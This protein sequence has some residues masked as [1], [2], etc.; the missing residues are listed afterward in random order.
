MMLSLFIDFKSPAAYL[1][2]KPALNLITSYELV[3][4]WLP[5][6]V[7]QPAIPTGRTDETLDERRL[8]IERETKGETH[9]RVRAEQREQMHKMYADLSNT[10]MHFP[11]QA[12]STDLALNVLANLTIDPTSFITR[13][14]QAYWIEELDLNDA[15]V[16]EQ[17]VHE[18]GLPFTPELLSST[19]MRACL[20]KAAERGV[21][22]VPAFV[23]DDQ[24]FIGREHM[25]WLTEL[26]TKLLQEKNAP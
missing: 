23:M 15:A 6:A 24:V 8:S 4:K 21:F 12:T 14:F 13:A 1:A 2:L 17:L 20:D 7:K 10:E 22:E 19:A 11:T 25:P 3:V 16:V 9:R 5:F 18:A 26:A